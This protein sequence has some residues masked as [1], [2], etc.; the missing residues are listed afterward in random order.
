MGVSKGVKFNAG[1]PVDQVSLGAPAFQPTPPAGQPSGQPVTVAGAAAPSPPAA[2][3]GTGIGLGAIIG[4]VVGAVV[5][6]LIAGMPPCLVHLVCNVRAMEIFWKCLAHPETHFNSQGVPA[7]NA[8]ILTTA[9]QQLAH[10]LPSTVLPPDIPAL[11][12]H[13]CA[14]VLRCPVVPCSAGGILRC[15][16]AAVARGPQVAE[17]VPERAG[18]AAPDFTA[19]SGARA[20]PLFRG[21][22]QGDS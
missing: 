16:E 11:T 14:R 9:C 8:V 1:I 2:S 18:S 19:V 3:S 4:I 7:T 10:M 20:R 15:A 21:R 17:A 5:A 22:H 6:L 13:S 12:L